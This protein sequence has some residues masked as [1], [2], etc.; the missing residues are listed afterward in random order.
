MRIIV[1]VQITC[2]DMHE[3]KSQDWPAFVSCFPSGGNWSE[4]LRGNSS[5][6]IRERR[7][8]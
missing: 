2:A 6:V 5:F 7:A 4:D 8:G 3:A 1:N